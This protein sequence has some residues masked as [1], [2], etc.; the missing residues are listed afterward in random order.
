MRL[1]VASLC[2]LLAAAAC[3]V[4]VVESSGGVG[5]GTPTPDGGGGSPGDGD[6]SGGG[7]GAT[8]DAGGGVNAAQ[9]C[10][11]DL[12]G[13]PS[14]KHNAGAICRECHDGSPAPNWTIA[15]TIYTT[16]D[17]DGPLPGATIEIT[18]ADGKVLT[19]KSALNGNFWTPEALTFPLTVRA[20]RCD[21]DETMPTQVETAGASCNSCHGLGSRIALP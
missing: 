15:G 6:G 20:T 17:A 1:H 14:G 2:V 12:A 21:A 19:L 3:E 9:N 7:G 11:V 5:S 13:L 4:G 16:V 8:P 18:D 10:E